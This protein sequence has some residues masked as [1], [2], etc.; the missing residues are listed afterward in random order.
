MRTRVA[1]ALPVLLLVATIAGVP[2]LRSVLRTADKAAAAQ[3]ANAEA[4]TS[5]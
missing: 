3:P 2:M 1:I 5:C 4:T